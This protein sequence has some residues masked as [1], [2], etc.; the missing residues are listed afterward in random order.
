[1]LGGAGDDQI[2]DP[3]PGAVD[4]IHCGPGEDFVEASPGDVVDADCERV[5]RT[6]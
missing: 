5:N 1:L 2:G 6:S 4:R 3:G